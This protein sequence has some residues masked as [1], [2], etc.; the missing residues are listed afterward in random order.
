MAT[1]ESGWEFNGA[2]LPPG[3]PALLVLDLGGVLVRLNMEAFHAAWAALGVDRRSLECFLRGPR[4]QDW[5]LGRIPAEDFP[6]LLRKDLGL[7]GWPAL[8]LREAWCAMIGPPDEALCHLAARAHG[9]GLRVGL[10]SNTDPW[11]WEVARERLP[12]RSFDPLGLSFDLAVLKPD[13]AIYRQVAAAGSPEL[14]WPD[15]GS[16]LF[17]DD[18]VEN[19]EAARECGWSCWHHNGESPRLDEL[20]ALLGLD[21]GEIL[22]L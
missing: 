16:I 20:E 10:L 11:H 9:A 4:N 15:A 21:T 6:R 7:P 3:G 13:A 19:L 12:F 2:G 17:V 18:R 5:N 1:P 8:R 14:A 22:E